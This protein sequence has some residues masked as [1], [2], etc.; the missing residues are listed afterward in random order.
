MMALDPSKRCDPIN[1]SRGTSNGVFDQ[2]AAT[3]CIPSS[4]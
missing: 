1:R 4:L 2:L 3:P